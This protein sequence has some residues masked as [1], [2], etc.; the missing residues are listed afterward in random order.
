MDAV[1]TLVVI[2]AAVLALLV[3]CWIFMRVAAWDRAH[4]SELAARKRV[5]ATL[6]PDVNVRPVAV[7]RKLHIIQET[8]DRCMD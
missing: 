1:A 6:L 7:S 8:L 3:V 5:E 2:G 4:E